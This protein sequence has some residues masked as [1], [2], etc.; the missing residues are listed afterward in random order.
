MNSNV[1]IVQTLQRLLLNSQI[2][3]LNEIMDLGIFTYLQFDNIDPTFSLH[4]VYLTGLENNSTMFDGEL[5]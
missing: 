4:A 3:R 2:E 5:Y 1:A